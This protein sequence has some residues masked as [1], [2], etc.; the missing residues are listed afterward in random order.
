MKKRLILLV[1][2]VSLFLSSCTVIVCNRKNAQPVCKRDYCPPV[3]VTACHTFHKD[4]I[5]R[6]VFIVNR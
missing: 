5:A 6:P 2:A 4:K 3:Q 1:F